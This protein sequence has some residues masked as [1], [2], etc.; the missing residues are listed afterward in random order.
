[1]VSRTHASG[2][3]P[4]EKPANSVLLKDDVGRAKPSSYRLPEI[5]FTYGRPLERDEEGAK[6]GII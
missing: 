3:Y 6:E 1:M 4:W 5:H 2:F